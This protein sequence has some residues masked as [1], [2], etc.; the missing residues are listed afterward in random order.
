[1]SAYL[2]SKAGLRRNLV[3]RLVLTGVAAYAINS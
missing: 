3:L 1:M 2:Q